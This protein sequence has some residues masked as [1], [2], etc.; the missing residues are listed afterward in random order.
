MI[1]D[2]IIPAPRKPTVSESGAHDV[3]AVDIEER[4]DTEEME[5]QSDVLG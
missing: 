4:S 3:V 1:A 5:R 2:A